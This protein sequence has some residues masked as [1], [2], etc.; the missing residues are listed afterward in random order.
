MFMPDGLLA[1]IPAARTWA[2]ELRRRQY[3]KPS[4]LLPLR[5]ATRSSKCWRPD[6]S[7]NSKYTV[8]LATWP[9]RTSFR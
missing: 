2:A 1:T 7:G 3:E 8:M 9:H 6:W 4:W 5:P